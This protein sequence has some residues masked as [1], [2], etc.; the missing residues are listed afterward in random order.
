[1]MT[2]VTT[3]EMIEKKIRDM[4]ILI[5]RRMK[6]CEIADGITIERVHTFFYIYLDMR[7]ID[8]LDQ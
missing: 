4:N 3:P 5:D 8:S 2:V 1:M 6:V 7:H